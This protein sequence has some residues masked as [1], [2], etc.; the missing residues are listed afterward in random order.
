MMAI[1]LE[2]PWFPEVM[3]LLDLRRRDRVLVINA[4]HPRFIKSV[5]QCVGTK[6]DVLVVDPN[7]KV[8][9]EVVEALPEVEVIALAPTGEEVFGRFDALLA[10]PLGM[11]DW[12]LELWAGIAQNNLRP[13]GRF[14]IDLPGEELCEDISACWLEIAGGEESL[15]PLRGPAEQTLATSLRQGGLRMV[16]AAMGT[17]LVRVDSPHTLASLGAQLLRADRDQQEEL[18]I[19][20]TRRLRT[21]GAVEVVFHR[22]RVHGIR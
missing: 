5:L 7:R 19:A 22:T 2:Y 12:P 16:A 20:L 10:C 14:A 1:D 6:G 9:T 18:G 17:H 11:P 8:A 13:G 3:E 4:Q 15:L 21:T